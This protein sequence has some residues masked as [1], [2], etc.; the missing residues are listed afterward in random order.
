MESMK[1]ETRRMTL[2]IL[3]FYSYKYTVR[4][5]QNEGKNY[6]KMH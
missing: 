3:F 4:S 1:I 5:D 6:E 2:G